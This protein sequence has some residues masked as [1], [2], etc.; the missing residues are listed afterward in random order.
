MKLRY[1]A[2]TASLGAVLCGGTVLAQSANIG[3]PPLPAPQTSTN[4]LSGGTGF[5]FIDSPNGAAPLESAVP[6]RR[7]PGPGPDL[8][9]SGAVTPDIWQKGR[10]AANTTSSAPAS[11]MKKGTPVLDVD[12]IKGAK[13]PDIKGSLQGL[14]DRTQSTGVQRLSPGSASDQIQP[15]NQPASK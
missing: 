10:P 9:D 2:M 13:D 14:S 5:P 3:G 7:V 12:A 8:N 4:R 6:S 15:V 1:F 11:E